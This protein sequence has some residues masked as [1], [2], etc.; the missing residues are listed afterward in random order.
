MGKQQDL[1]SKANT[2]HSLYGEHVTL[3]N[4]HVYPNTNSQ[5]DLRV[6]NTISQGF[7]LPLAPGD[8]TYQDVKNES[9]NPKRDCGLC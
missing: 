6:A 4:N 1:S 3:F 8:V 7:E 2:I 9:Y 5:T